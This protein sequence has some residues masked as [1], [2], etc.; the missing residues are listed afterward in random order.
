MFHFS[1]FISHLSDDVILIT[2]TRYK[3]MWPYLISGRR[4]DFQGCMYGVDD[5]IIRIFPSV[6]AF[7]FCGT[8]ESTTYH[9]KSSHLCAWQVICHCTQTCLL[10]LHF[11]KFCF[12]SAVKNRRAFY[13]TTHTANMTW[14]II[15]NLFRVVLQ[16]QIIAFLFQQQEQEHFW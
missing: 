4:T 15:Y 8:I 14:T 9:K 7:F 1:C 16:L 11:V 3:I 6:S 2:R 12:K 13:L 10:P 5:K